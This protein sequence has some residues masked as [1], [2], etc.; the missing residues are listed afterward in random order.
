MTE[1]IYR[2]MEQDTLFRETLL[3]TSEAKLVE[4]ITSSQFWGC[5][6][7]DSG[8]NMMGHILMAV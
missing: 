7:N 2:R 8:Y 3:N 6:H 4:N 5:G 1:I